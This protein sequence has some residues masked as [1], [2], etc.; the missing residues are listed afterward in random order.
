MC[1]QRIIPI[2]LQEKVYFLQNYIW[3]AE[4]T[5]RRTVMATVGKRERNFAV[6]CRF[7]NGSLGIPRL[8][9]V[10]IPPHQPD[11]V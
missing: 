10:V 11:A 1:V 5:P 9:T 3:S 2:H 7:N 8:D 6:K 4:E